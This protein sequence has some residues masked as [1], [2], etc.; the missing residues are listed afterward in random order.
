M[1]KARILFL[2]LAGVLLLAGCQKEGRIGGKDAIR[3]S[4]ESNPGTKTV[5]AGEGANGRERI[6][7]RE[8]DEIRIFSD[9]SEHRYHEGQH[10]ADYIITSVSNSGSVSKGKIDNVPGDGTGNGLIWKEAGDY[11]FFAIY[12]PQDQEYGHKGKFVANI[13]NLQ[14]IDITTRAPFTPS[15]D[16]AVMTAATNITTSVDGEGPTINMEF[17]PAY[18]AFEFTFNSDMP[19]EITRMVLVRLNSSTGEMYPLAGQYS[20]EYDED[21]NVSYNPTS[22]SNVIIVAFDEQKPKVTADDSFTFSAFTLPIDISNLEFSLTVKADDWDAAETRVLKLYYKNGEPVTFAGGLKH[23][24]SAT[25]QGAH[26][27]KSITLN[28]EAVDWTEETVTT[29]SNETPQ[30]TQFAVTGAG[31]KNVYELHKTEANKVYRQ[32]WVLGENTANVSFKIFSPVGG[33]YKVKPYV[34]KADGTIVEGSD[35]FT[36][37]GDLTG[38]IGIA[39]QEHVATKVKFTVAVNGAANGDQLFFMTMVKDTDD[40]L[41]NLDSETQLFDTRGYHYFMVNDPLE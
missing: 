8:N 26:N 3:F 20:I 31:I 11:K 30:S 25:I 28:G 37:T 40:V 12:P 6:N 38:D 22:A 16:Y 17:E 15:M 2:L 33:E 13:P 1:K 14:T 41:Y 4:A 29:N 35:G 36:I 27:F 32:T 39:G 10:W 34:K 5:Y 7:W 23:K 19:L 18:T 24:I 21:Q 9:K